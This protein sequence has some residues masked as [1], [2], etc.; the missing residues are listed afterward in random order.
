MPSSDASIDFFRRFSRFFPLPSVEVYGMAVETKTSIFN[1][2]HGCWKIPWNMGKVFA[3]SARLLR[4]LWWFIRRHGSAMLKYKK[5]MSARC[6]RRLIQFDRKI[7][8]LSR[9]CL[10]FVFIFH[11]FQREK[12]SRMKSNYEIHKMRI[13][14]RGAIVN[15]T[16]S[17]A[18]RN[19]AKCKEASIRLDNQYWCACMRFI[20]CAAR[21]YS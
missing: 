4:N 18:T 1:K 11:K 7:T 10:F 3:S 13:R 12:R 19:S 8:L 2:L 20:M 9:R 6:S 16:H 5:V 15:P 21:T 17:S 14:V